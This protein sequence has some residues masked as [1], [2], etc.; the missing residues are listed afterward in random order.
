MEN[1]QKMTH[2]GERVEHTKMKKR[3]DFKKDRNDVIFEVKGPRIYNL[4]SRTKQQ[5][6]IDKG[7]MLRK[8][9]KHV[10]ANQQ[11]T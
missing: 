3:S 9:T 1:H 11:I 7:N 10:K 6:R 8:H 2:P 4:R 5:N